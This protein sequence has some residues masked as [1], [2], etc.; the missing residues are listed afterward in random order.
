MRPT[1]Y[2][3]LAVLVVLSGIALCEW[4]PE[5]TEDDEAV[6]SQAMAWFEKTA[7]KNGGDILPKGYRE[8]LLF[9]KCFRIGDDASGYEAIF[10][11]ASDVRQLGDG[12]TDYVWQVGDY[13]FKVRVGAVSSEGGTRLV[14]LKKGFEIWAS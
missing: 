5:A 11:T 6:H 10:A 7:K 8:E 9:K 12:Q 14:I 4:W 3:L 1:T 13:L 2:C